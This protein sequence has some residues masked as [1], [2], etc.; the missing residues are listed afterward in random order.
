M[1]GS[2]KAELSHEDVIDELLPEAWGF[3]CSDTVLHYV[4][5]VSMNWK[6]HKF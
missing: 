5:R 6:T 4:E 3:G 2:S 1:G